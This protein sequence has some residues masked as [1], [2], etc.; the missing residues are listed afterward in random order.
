MYNRYQIM[1]FSICIA[2]AAPGFV[3]AFTTPITNPVVVTFDQTTAERVAVTTFHQEMSNAITVEYGS[4]QYNLMKMRAVGPMV[5]VGHGNADGIR[6]QNMVVSAKQ[7]QTEISTT[8]AARIYLLACDSEEIADFDKSGRT[9]GYS[10]MVDAELAAF[11]AAIRIK[12]F[13]GQID[14]AIET[15]KTFREVLTAKFIGTN[16]YMPLGL[17]GGGT[18]GGGGTTSPVFSTAEKLNAVKVFGLGC[19]F[20]LIGFGISVAGDKLSDAIDKWLRVDALG[21]PS[22]QPSKVV[23]IFN[24]VKDYGIGT[25]DVA[26]GNIYGGWTD[27]AAAWLDTSVNILGDW[28]DSMS[29]GEWAVF[30]TYCA[31][32]IVVTILTAG[33]KA[34]VQLCVGIGFAG[35]EAATIAIC[36]AHDSNT[37]PASGV[38]DAISSWT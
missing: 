32:D 38:G 5:F 3:A 17:I 11:D 35:L 31:L 25:L 37:Y 34:W 27:M 36:D 14:S 1:V 21:V 28:L 9:H 2:I 24:Y 10:Y 6:D 4:L 29:A 12:L 33:S 13:L 15:F 19:I 23:K 18:I 22:S 16:E 7:I 30:L 8:A 20:A 26:V